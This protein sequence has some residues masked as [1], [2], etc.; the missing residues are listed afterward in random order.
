M[1]GRTD[2]VMGR[3]RNSLSKQFRGNQYTRETE[4]Q[5]IKDCEEGA[6]RTPSVRGRK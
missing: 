5:Y 6:G 4:D 3:T 1:M 2:R